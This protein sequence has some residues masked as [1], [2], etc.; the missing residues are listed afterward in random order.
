MRSEPRPVVVITGGTAG[1]GRATARC[2]AAE[3]AHIAL[4]ARGVDGLHATAREIAALGGK[5]L[6]IRADV[7]DPDQVFAAAERIERELGPIDIWI[8]NAMTTVF[9]RVDQLAP[10]ELR[11]VTDVTYHGYVWGTMAALGSMRPRDRGTIVQVGSALAHRAIPLQAAYCAAKHAIVGFTDALRSELLHDGSKIQITM[12]QL[13]A[14]NTPQFRWCENKLGLEAQP[15]P[16]IYQ[17]EIAAGAIHFA[18]YHPRREIYVGMPTVKAIL[19]QKVAPGLLDRILAKRGFEGQ[20]TGVPIRNPR[21]SN[22]FEPVPGDHGAHGS[23]E[24]RAKRHSPAARLG[25]WLG[26]AGVNAVAVAL[27]AGIAVALTRL[28][29]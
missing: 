2:F 11:R 13:P 18:A 24:L 4:L 28:R 29:A 10:E 23:F 5:A 19:G 6:P 14:I 22:L 25:A 16:P 3:G 12:V 1:V 15:V 21:P 17:P 7:S 26:A 8:N 20:T 27:V 9:G